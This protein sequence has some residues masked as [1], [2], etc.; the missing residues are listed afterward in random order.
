MEPVLYMMHNN[1]TEGHFATDA[2]FNKIRDQYY[3][4]QL[5]EDIRNYVRTCDSC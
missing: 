5:Y 2:M 4:P 3:W 1:P